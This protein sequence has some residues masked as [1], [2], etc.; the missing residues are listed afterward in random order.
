MIGNISL[1]LWKISR[2]KLAEDQEQDHRKYWQMQLRM[3]LILDNI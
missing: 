2:S 3:I 1:K